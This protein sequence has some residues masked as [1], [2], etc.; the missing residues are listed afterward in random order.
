MTFTLK[1]VQDQLRALGASPK[2]SLGQN[3]LINPQAISKIIEST[4]RLNFDSIIEVGPGLGAL[5]LPLLEMKKPTV[6]IELDREFARIWRDK[7][8]E[9]VEEDA[10][11]VDWNTLPVTG[12]KLLISN[13]PYQISASLVIDRSVEPAGVTS[14]VLMFQ[15]EVAQRMF[16]KPNTEAYSLVSVIAQNAW[17]VQ[18]VMEIS[19]KDFYPPP[20]VASQVLRF[21]RVGNGVSEA[22][23]KF[24]KL[25]F[26]HRRKL[27]IKNISGLADSAV[28]EQLW[29]GLK[30]DRNA[31]PEDLSPEKFKALFESL[32]K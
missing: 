8:V 12:S 7:G 31:R 2:K 29:E 9:V 28:L 24:V 23:L 22:F 11:R 26:A 1:D 5:T 4:L 18:K 3:F 25:A 19:S 10:L 20:A 15:K 16:A 30:L 17:R 14:M 27:L 32:A 21:E 6:L 13:L